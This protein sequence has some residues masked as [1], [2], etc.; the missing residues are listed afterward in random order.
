MTK[1]TVLFE[2]TSTGYSA[3]V[4]DLPG[5]VAAAATLEEARELVKE[6]IEFHLE[7]MRLHCE[8]VPPP[9]TRS[10]EVDVPA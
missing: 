10:E 5:C 3:H 1:Y 4:P 9:A 8:A 7:R 6:A 2:P